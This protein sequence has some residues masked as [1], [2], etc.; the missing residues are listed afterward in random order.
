MRTASLILAGALLLAGCD[1]S[2]GDN[3]DS[4]WSY[5][6]VSGGGPGTGGGWVIITGHGKAAPAFVFGAAFPFDGEIPPPDEVA[7]A[8]PPPEGFDLV[9]ALAVPDGL[10]MLLRGTDGVPV[11]TLDGD[12]PQPVPFP[13]VRVMP[14][15]PAPLSILLL[16][17]DGMAIRAVRAGDS[18]ES[19]H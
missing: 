1:G 18:T 3:G 5:T 12:L 10:V 7:R 14:E 19:E 8:T 6:F 2:S 15:V 9:D 13:A 11:L 17:A 4:D 16:S